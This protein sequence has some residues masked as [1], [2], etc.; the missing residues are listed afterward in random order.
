MSSTTPDHIPT[1]TL[2]TINDL[3][4][5]LLWLI[6]DY[7]LEPTGTEEVENRIH[8]TEAGGYQATSWTF[9]NAFRRYRFR[10]VK[11]TSAEG[12]LKLAKLGDWPNVTAASRSC[13]GTDVNDVSEDRD[14]HE[15]EEQ[16]EEGEVDSSSNNPLRLQFCSRQIESLDLRC[17]PPNLDAY[18]S[19]FKSSS[20][21]PL[22]PG[23]KSLVMNMASLPYSDQ[24]TLRIDREGILDLDCAEKIKTISQIAPSTTRFTIKFGF[25]G[26]YNGTRQELL[27]S[28]DPSCDPDSWKASEEVVVRHIAGVWWKEGYF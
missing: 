7:T 5:E 1:P 14:E 25:G 8:N 17:L 23:L 27:D 10:S 13:R 18:T 9:Y 20:P 4:L 11:V 3:P 6:A 15:H 22:F 19:V 26:E 24:E 21:K 16:E 12:F 28:L 2:A